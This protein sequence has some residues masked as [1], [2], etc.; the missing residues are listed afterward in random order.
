MDETE[1]LVSMLIEMGCVKMSQIRPLLK[2][3]RE[4]DRDHSGTLSKNDLGVIIRERERRHS[5]LTVTPTPATSQPIDASAS[6]GDRDKIVRED[7]AAPPPLM[8]R[9][10]LP[11][12]K[13]AS[14]PVLVPDARC[15]CA[16]A[17]AAHMQRASGTSTHATWR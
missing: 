10:G 11:V 4:L 7:S 17:H 1:F 2:K 5:A 16:G 8:G 13:S 14:M 3:F 6:V 15:M 12:R 9:A